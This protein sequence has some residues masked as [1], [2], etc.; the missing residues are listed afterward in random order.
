MGDVLLVPSECNTTG[1]EKY[2]H[3][4]WATMLGVMEGAKSTCPHPCLAPNPTSILQQQESVSLA[5]R[6]ANLVRM[7]ILALNVHSK[8]FTYQ[9]AAVYP[10]AGMEL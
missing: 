5:S 4:L 8:D 1:K 2:V 6:A 7:L 9:Q 10:N 3:A